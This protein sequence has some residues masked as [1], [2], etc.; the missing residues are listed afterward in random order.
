VKRCVLTGEEATIAEV[1][2]ALS[3]DLG[4][5]PHARI[6]LDALWDVLSTDVEGPISV[7]WRNA[8]EARRRLGPAFDDLLGVLRDVAATRG[9]FSLTVD[10]A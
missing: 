7:E 4:F 2:R 1:H 5:P 3:R 8:A 9:D 6:N 10:E